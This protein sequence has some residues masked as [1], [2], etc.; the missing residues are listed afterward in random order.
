MSWGFINGSPNALG[1]T[2]ALAQFLLAGQA[3]TTLP[4]VN[5][6]IAQLGQHRDQPDDF[7]RLAQTISTCDALLIG[8]PVYWSDMTGLLKTFLDRC[9]LIA[10]QVAFRH[11]PTYVL[12]NGTQRPAQTAPGIAPAI[13]QLADFLQ[14]DYRDTIV[15]DTSLVRPPAF[16]QVL[17]PWQQQLQEAQHD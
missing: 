8:T 17:T 12:V 14:W 10:K 3:C 9:T 1:H 5:Y 7:I 6:H 11:V 2:D 16:A 13:A 15:V 4:L